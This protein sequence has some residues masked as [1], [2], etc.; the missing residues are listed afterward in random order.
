MSTM[1]EKRDYYEVLGVS[2][3]ASQSEISSAYRRLAIKYHPDT[4]PGDEE[5]TERFK[6]AAEAYEVLLDAEKKAVYDRYGHAGLAGSGGGGPGFT[7]VEDIFEAFGDMFGFGD[8]FGRRRGGRR[9]RRGADIKCEVTLTLEEAARGVTKSVKFNRSKLC[10]V[11][12][13]SRSKPGSSPVRCHVCN[14]HG[15]VVQSAGILRV[16][17]TCPK[18]QG[19][20]NVIQHPCQH[21]RGRGFTADRVEM[22]V[23][24]PAGVDDGMRVRLSG[25]GEPSHEGGSPGDCYC[26][27]HVREHSLFE[28]DGAHLFLRLPITFS[29]AALGA[30]V[31]VPTLQGRRELKIGP[32]T[33]SG[34]IFKLRG[35]GMPDPQGGPTGDLVVR[36]DVEVPKTLTSRQE[37]LLR[38]LAELE[39]THV[40]AHRKSFMDK[41]RDYFSP[42]ETD[43]NQEV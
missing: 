14:G 33:D 1:A 39:N 24:I 5:A 26:F 4:N 19:S 34:Q 29:Q 25:E 40:S 9:K 2:R 18:C 30:A 15:Q 41:I 36:T 42:S 3:N 20:G 43:E 11:C 22:D 27:I 21:C 37:E 13:G 32:G 23:K 12:H 35:C 38:E 7:D 31:E 8:V 10:S 28:R 16:Q 6:E 17:S